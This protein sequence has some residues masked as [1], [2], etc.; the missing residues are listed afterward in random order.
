MSDDLSIY[1]NLRC[2]KS[3][4]TLNL[5]REAGHE[6]DIILYLE[7]PPTTKQL[8]KLLLALGVS[9]RD[10]MRKNEA[11]YKDLQ[12]DRDS[13]DENELIEQMVAHPILIERPIVVAGTQAALGRP[14]ERALELLGLTS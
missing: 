14:P 12:L 6:P 1:H 3:R 5:L 2:S 8:A 10:L 9:A 11:I 4:K 13:L 7:T